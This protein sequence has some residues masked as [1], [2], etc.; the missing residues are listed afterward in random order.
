MNDEG[1]KLLAF[2]R[3]CGA[4]TPYVVH[5]AILDEDEYDIRKLTGFFVGYGNCNIRARW[6]G[7]RLLTVGTD[8]DTNLKMETSFEDFTILYVK[9]GKFDDSNQTP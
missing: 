6:E 3:S 7:T 1:S 5:L 8:C 4:T 9:G 2:E